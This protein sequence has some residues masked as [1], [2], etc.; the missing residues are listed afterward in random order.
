MRNIL[1]SGATAVVLALGA[2][3]AFANGPLYSPYEI[4]APQPTDQQ[5]A[6]APE[7]GRASYT[8]DNQ[9]CRPARERVHGV[10][11]NVLICN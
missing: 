5:P 2:S 11:R 8:N 1:L 6:A 7:E 3:S 4:L 9:N 10:W